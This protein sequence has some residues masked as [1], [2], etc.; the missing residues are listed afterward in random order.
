MHTHTHK[1]NFLKTQSKKKIY[2]A[3][4]GKKNY[5]KSA[6]IKLT[7]DSQQKP[8]NNSTNQDSILR[9]RGFKNK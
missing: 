5:V 9:K 2:K 6:T 1:K 7:S 8:P 4:R 3:A